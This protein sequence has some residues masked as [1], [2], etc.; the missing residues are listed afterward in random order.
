MCFLNPYMQRSNLP[1]RLYTQ[2]L[3]YSTFASNIRLLLQFRYLLLAQLG[4]T[5]LNVLFIV[6][7]LYL[8]VHVCVCACT[9][10][11][12]AFVMGREEE[13][14]M[15]CEDS[16]DT[17]D[18]EDEDSLEVRLQVNPLTWRVYFN[19]YLTMGGK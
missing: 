2:I 8:C 5:Y 9:G 4:G 10:G 13:D 14:F 17:E 6:L 12:N 1:E 19:P 18:E 15:I 7:S 3:Y 16:S 11:L